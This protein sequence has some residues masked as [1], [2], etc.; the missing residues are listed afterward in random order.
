MS[1][2]QS[3]AME[4]TEIIDETPLIK[5]FVFDKKFEFRAG[6]F[7]MV[8][9]PGVDEVPM[10]LSSGNS[11]TVQKAG[12]AT[13]ALFGFKA[14]DKLGIRAPLGNGFS[15]SGKVLAVAGG[16]GAAPLRPLA[17]SGRCDTFLLGSRNSDE[18]LYAGELSEVCRFMIATDDGSKGHHGFVTELMQDIDLAFF[19][20][21]CVC[22]PEIMMKGVLDIL[23]S[24]GIA[25]RGQFSLAR[26][27]KCGVGICGS[28]CIDPD[29]LRV[30]RDGPVFSG[31]VL[32]KSSEFG[33][34]SRDASGRKVYARG[35]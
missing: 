19:D 1:D 4:I 20:T 24:K 28:C 12:P 2:I 18:L 7:C 21:V 33:N 11:I 9:I 6:Q 10:G 27:M 14:G 15:P 23:E 17:M 26:Y 13:T 29:G 3:Y 35:H 32:L 34:Y 30:C 5:T 25:G 22:G 16:V 31:D 8:W